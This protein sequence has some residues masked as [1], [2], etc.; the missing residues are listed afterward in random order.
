MYPCLAQG[1]RH[2]STTSYGPVSSSPPF[3]WSIAGD[4]NRPVP[5]TATTTRSR[6][7]TWS[8][9]LLSPRRRPRG[10]CREAERDVF[11]RVVAAAHGDD[12]VL[13][14]VDRVGHRRAALRR[15]HPDRAD[16]SARVLVVRAQHRPA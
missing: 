12:D 3:S 4:E 9:V 5:K 1:A 6:T 14:A 11:A 2:L 7:R 16:L 8:V 10:R 15:G 13:P